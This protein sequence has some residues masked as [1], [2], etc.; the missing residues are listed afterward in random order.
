MMMMMMM[1]QFPNY[2][3]DVEL[4]HIIFSINQP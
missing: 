2:L 3:L 1:M 4:N